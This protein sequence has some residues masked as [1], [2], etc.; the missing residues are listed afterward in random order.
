MREA[1]RSQNLQAVTAINRKIPGSM[2]AGSR[3]G[4]GIR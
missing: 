4:S 3:H 1:Y 2:E